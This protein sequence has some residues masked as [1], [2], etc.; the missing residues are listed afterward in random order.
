M[1]VDRYVPRRHRKL[2]KEEKREVRGILEETVAVQP[3]VKPKAKK[4]RAAKQANTGSGSATTAPPHGR[5]A[6]N[7]IRQQANTLASNAFKA[8]AKYLSLPGSIAP[9]RWSAGFSAT[10]TAVASP[11]SVRKANWALGGTTTVMNASEMLGAV[12]RLAECAVIQ[13]EYNAA[14]ANQTYRWLVSTPTTT[15]VDTAPTTTFTLA[16][17]GS[18][19]SWVPIVVA[20][21]TTAYKPH[22]NAKFAAS[23]TGQKTDPQRYM[24]LDKGEIATMDAAGLD[25]TAIYYFKL[26]GYSSSAEL[27]PVLEDSITG[28]ASGSFSMTV[29]ASGYYAFSMSSNNTGNTEPI[30]CA[31]FQTGGTHKEVFTHQ[32]IPGYYEK[33]SSIGKQRISAVSILYSNEA[34][35]VSKS[36][37][38]VGYQSPQDI[39]WYDYINGY[40]KLSQSKGADPI[41]ALNGQYGFLKPTK[42]DDFNVKQYVSISD[43][44]LYDSFWPIVADSDYLIIYLQISD[45]GGQVGRF[46]YN[47]GLEFLTPDTWF[48][49]RSSELP[50]ATFGAAIEFMSK[51]KQ[52]HENP[53]HLGEIWDSIKRGVGSAANAVIKYG[54]QAIGLAGMLAGMV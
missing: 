32:S 37:N 40:D 52:W 11:Y 10:D 43:A 22:G 13:F 35:P 39:P 30:D 16:V 7:A 29:P 50:S 20:L 24:W 44:G 51:L 12:F 19:E 3:A 15:L 25:V 34:A 6:D 8:V 5:R 42:P 47:W 41:P 45:T 54:P 48:N 17:T 33:I 49:Q 46:T 4:R 53:L 14:A 31:D 38:M 27:E 2:N 36:G 23:R 18:Q 9:F 26:W 28:A 1:E 21:P